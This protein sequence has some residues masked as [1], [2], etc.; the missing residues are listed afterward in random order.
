LHN[1]HQW[2]EG[3]REA[4]EIAI[5]DDDERWLEAACA[6]LVSMGT[7][8]SPIAQLVAG[9]NLKSDADKATAW[10]LGK[11]AKRDYPDRLIRCTLRDMPAYD[12]GAANV[13][14]EFKDSPLVIRELT[15]LLKS[16]PTGSIYAA[17]VLVRN[18]QTAFKS[19]AVEA[20]GK[21]VIDPSTPYGAWRTAVWLL[22]DYGSD[23]Q[24]GVL[25]ASLRRLKTA[26]EAQYRSLF[27]AI[28]DRQSKRALLADAVLLNDRR[29]WPTSTFRYCDMAVASIE[30]ISGERFGMKQ[31]ITLEERDRA[32]AAASAWLK[33]H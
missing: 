16:D 12:W 31:E 22:R 9:E 13:L 27:G 15:T 5:G 20:A 25:I 33:S 6:V 10:L 8:H 11:G 21:L 17:Y 23:G 26:D 14:L 3:F 4:L 29:P 32:V 19:E 7:P 18:G 2:P 30:A 28:D 24:F 1:D